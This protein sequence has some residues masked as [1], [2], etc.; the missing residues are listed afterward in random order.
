MSLF[1]L[2]ICWIL[3]IAR[4]HIIVNIALFWSEV[5]M[6]ARKRPFVEGSLHDALQRKCIHKNVCHECGV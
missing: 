2:S 5:E 6:S 1:M 3:L 4:A